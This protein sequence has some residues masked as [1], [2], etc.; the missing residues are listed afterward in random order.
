M[1]AF[2]R[3]PV[4]AQHRSWPGACAPWGPALVAQRWDFLACL[5]HVPGFLHHGNG[6]GIPLP[7]IEF[8]QIFGTFFDSAPGHVTAAL[9]LIFGLSATLRRNLQPTER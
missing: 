7:G 6:Y 3:P 2:F 8:Q 5:R 4:T 1:A 9:F